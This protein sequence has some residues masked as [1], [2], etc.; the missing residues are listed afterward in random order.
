MFSNLDALLEQARDRFARGEYAQAV[1]ACAQLLAQQEQAAEA[2]HIQAVSLQAMG[3]LTAALEAYHRALALEPTRPLYWV[4]CANGLIAAQAYDEAEQALNKA[5]ALHPHHALATRA[6]VSLR[7]TQER[8]EEAEAI[9]T[10]HHLARPDVK[11]TLV[12]LTGLY[13]RLER[14]DEAEVAC[15]QILAGD[16]PDALKDAAQ[17]TLAQGLRARARYDEAIAL[18]RDLTARK[19]DVAELRLALGASLL[20]VGLWDEAWPH[21]E[22]RSVRHRH[23][24]R[25]QWTGQALAGQSIFVHAEQGLGDS[26]MA[27]RFL[28]LLKQAGAT[29]HLMIQDELASL[30]QEGLGDSLDSIITIS[31]AQTHLP[32]VIDF[33]VPMMSL[34]RGFRLRPETVPA[35]TPY[36]RIRQT[37]RLGP[38][39]GEGRRIGLVWAGS[40]HFPSDHQRSIPFDA[41]RSLLA[42]PHGQFYS[43]QVGPRAQQAAQ[44]FASGSLTDLSPLLSDFL[45]TAGLIQEMDLIITVDT[46]VAHLAGALAKP[47]WI[48]LPF[49]G[50]FRWLRGRDDSVWYP[51]ARLFRQPGLGDW[52][53]VLDSVKSALISIP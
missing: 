33:H 48:L 10:A 50:D 44:D 7:I 46:A 51:T 2:W 35:Q 32:K 19:P 5:L 14:Y 15:R 9:L 8:W 26:I 11:E 6:L 25:P 16:W 3:N 31:Q 20:T 38:R 24:N 52:P 12:A 41:M 17:E 21:Y 28:P 23:I 45:Q 47:V 42:V 29:V 30:M 34:P 43:F 4:N 37:Q 40:A 39:T 36:L 13:H 53:S 18:L 1:E 22:Y 49:A 27:A